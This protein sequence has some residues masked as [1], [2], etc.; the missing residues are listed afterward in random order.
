MTEADGSEGS[1]QSSF[2]GGQGAGYS[3]EED[4]QRPLLLV[5]K[6]DVSDITGEWRTEEV[7]A[8]AL[9]QM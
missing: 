7:E 5:R 9:E 4:W 6:E 1:L 2:C 3:V 8:A